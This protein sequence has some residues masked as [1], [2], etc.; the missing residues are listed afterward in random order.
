MTA[1]WVFLSHPIGRETPTFFTNPPVER[2]SQTTVRANGY[3][4]ELV[5]MLN[6]TGSHVDAPSHFIELGASVDALPA[7]KWV[8]ENPILVDVPT[9]S[10]HLVPPDQ[11]YSQREPLGSA[12]LVLVRTG[13]E[14]YRERPERWSFHN[15]GLSEQLALALVDL[16]PKA[17][18]VGIDLPSASAAQAMADGA[19]FHRVWLG[20]SDRTPVIFEDL[21]LSEIRGVRSLE[22]VIALPMRLIRGD[23]A[24]CTVIGRVRRHQD[25]GPRA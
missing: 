19:A 14:R 4:Q 2:E 20:Q 25:G 18:A 13:F 16:C 5:T 6:H 17:R 21:H 7:D 24:P 10:D 3:S 15:P 12:D 23:G 22:L 1:S 8:F 11:V 9:E